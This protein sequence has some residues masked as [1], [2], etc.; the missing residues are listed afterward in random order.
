M[1]ELI[2]RLIEIIKPLTIDETIAASERKII[3][4]GYQIL[5][6]EDMETKDRIQRSCDLFDDA[7]KSPNNPYHSRVELWRAL[8]VHEDFFDG[9]TFERSIEPK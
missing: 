9:K 1:I 7:S 3:E 6:D 4:E 5:I 2:N 8:A